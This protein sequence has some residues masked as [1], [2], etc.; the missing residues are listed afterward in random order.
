MVGVRSR[1]LG[2][3]GD[4]NR[5]WR[6]PQPPG[7]GRW[8]L[9]TTASQPVF[10]ELYFALWAV[11]IG[12]GSQEARFQGV[13]RIE[14]RSRLLSELELVNTLALAG[15]SR[16]VE[17]QSVNKKVASSIPGQGRRLGCWGCVSVL[18]SPSFL[19]SLKN[20]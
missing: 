5:G 1:G 11:S 4:S 10:T 9:G 3:S 20:K 6:R 16:W 7:R 19:L 13:H 8:P 12:H 18:F 14:P 17:H 15:V 2:W